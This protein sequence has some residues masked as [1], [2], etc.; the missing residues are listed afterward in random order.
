M[1]E[2]G[3]GKKRPSTGYGKGLDMRPTGMEESLS[4]THKSVKVTSASP[5]TNIDPD[6]MKSGGNIVG[7]CSQP[8][9]GI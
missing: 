9:K 8:V 1:H 4:G 7:C 3:R 2:Y 5:S 6:K